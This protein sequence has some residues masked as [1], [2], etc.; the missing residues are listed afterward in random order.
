MSRDILASYPALRRTA[1]RAM[2]GFA[3][4]CPMPLMRLLAHALGSLAYCVDARGRRT[5]GRNLSHFI[6]ASAP[7]ARERAVLASYRN[8]ATALGEGLRLG[9]LPETYLA[10]ERLRVVDPWKVFASRPLK[11]PAILVTVH[12]NWALLL[13]AAHHLRFF[14]QVEAISLSHGDPMIDH[15]FERKRARAG[16]RSLLLDR[17]PLAALRALKGERILGVLADRD[18][19]GNGVRVP[20]GD[21]YMAV[22]PG[23]AALAVQ[24]AS[25]IIPMF[26]ARSGP[27]SFVLIVAKPL[28]ADEREPKQRQVRQLTERLSRTLGR[29]IAAAPAQWVA[30][31]DAWGSGRPAR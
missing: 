20:F 13:A 30:F 15:L 18:Y 7:Q 2:D 6:P 29:F 19:T 16:C 3:N 22:P 1:Y 4:R 12:A 23:P 27:R 14:E 24:T 8:F 9:S 31:H 25:P 28:H 10:P 11:G 21:H 26:L 17:A 5:V